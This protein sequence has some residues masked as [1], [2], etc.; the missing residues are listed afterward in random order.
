MHTH[1]IYKYALTGEVTELTM[2]PDAEVLDVQYQRGV[3]VL[4][5]RARPAVPE[6]ARQK[7]YF[8]TRPTGHEYKDT[9]AL[10]A[11]TYVATV[12]DLNNGLVWHIFEGEKT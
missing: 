11:E 9:D 1:I 3:L 10:R 12:Q 7:R 4:W 6:H 2:L 5:A 8:W